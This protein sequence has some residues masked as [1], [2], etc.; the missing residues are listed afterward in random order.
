M[1]QKVGNRM[2]IPPAFSCH[3]SYLKIG[4]VARAMNVRKELA[5]NFIYIPMILNLINRGFSLNKAN[6]KSYLP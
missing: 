6:I 2:I 4:S 1:E 3:P 5:L